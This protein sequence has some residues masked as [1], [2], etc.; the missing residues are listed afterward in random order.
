MSS[1]KSD[2]QEDRDRGRN[3][4]RDDDRNE[5]SDHS[6]AVYGQDEHG[7][8]QV[9]VQQ[10]ITGTDKKDDLTGTSGNDTIFG[11]GGNDKIDGGDGNDTIDAG[12]GNDNIEGGK[13]DD[14]ITGGAGND[15]IDGGKGIDV[16]VY[17][18]NFSDYKLTLSRDGGHQG[19]DDDDHSAMTVHDLRSGAPDGVDV[20]KNVEVLRF[21]DGE[22]KDGQFHPSLRVTAVTLLSD[23]TG[24][25]NSDFVTSQALQTVTGTFGGTLHTGDIIEVSADGNTWVTA[26][27]TGGSTWSATGITLIP[28]SG[29]QIITR[30]IDSHGTILAGASHSYVL[31]TTVA[32][33][34]LS[35]AYDESGISLTDAITNATT[36]TLS[37]DAE[38]GATVKVY[39]GATLIGTVTANA[40]GA[41]SLT[42]SGLA[43]GTHNFSAAQTDLA[44]N[45]SGA[46]TVSSMTVDTVAL[47][48]SL[49]AVFADSG[50][51]S[52]DKITNAIN[53]TLSGTAEKG[54]AVHVYD[55]ALS[56]GTVT[57]N[58]ATGAW[59]LNVT[60]L[61][62][63]AHSFTATQ[64]DVAGNLSGSSAAKT[65]TVD[66]AAAA[67]LVTPIMGDGIINA[68]EQTNVTISGGTT[69][70]EA[71][72]PLT[73][74]VSDGSATVTGTATVVSDGSWSATGLDFSGLNEGLLTVSVSGTDVAGNLA[75]ATTELNKDSVAS[76]TLSMPIATDGI[77]NASEKT[78]VTISGTTEGVEEGIWLT[79]SV[80]GGTSSVTGTAMVGPGGAWTGDFGLTSLTDGPLT[81]SVSGT[82]AAGN[83]VSA[84]TTVVLDA[85]VTMPLLTLASDTGILGTDGITSVGTVNVGGLEA[86]AS[87]QYSTDNGT[88]WVNGTGSSLTL[89]GD[90]TKSVLVQQT[91]AAGNTSA[92]ATLDLTLDTSI[93]TPTITEVYDSVGTIGPVA[94]GDVTDDQQPKLSGQAEAGSTVNVFDGS[95]L[96]GTTLADGNGDWTFTPVTALAEAQHS[97]TVTATDTAGNSS[98]SSAYGIGISLV[99]ENFAPALTGTPAALIGG[100]E[101]LPYTVSSE[102]LLA[103]FTDGNSGDVLSVSGLSADHGTVT[104]NGNGTYT[105]TPTP[106]YNGPVTLSYQVTDGHAGYSQLTTLSF[107]LTPAPDAAVIGAPSVATV[108]E[109]VLVDTYGN[110]NAQGIIPITDADGASQ[111]AFNPVTLSGALGSLALLASGSYTYTVDNSAVQLLGASAAEV[112]TF[113]VSSADGTTQNLSFAV[114][115]ANDA[116]VIGDPTLATVSEDADVNLDGNLVLTDTLSITDAD[117]GEDSFSTAVSAVGTTLGSLILNTNGVYTYSVANVDVQYLGGGETATDTFTVTAADGTT[118]EVS[119]AIAGANDTPTLAASLITADFFDGAAK[120]VFAPVTGALTTTDAD[121]NATHTYGIAGGGTDT[122]LLGYDSSLAGAYGTLYLNSA[123]GNYTYVPNSDAI[124]TMP[125]GSTDMDQFSL[126]VDDHA[127]GTASQ[128]LAINL[129]GANDASVIDGLRGPPDYSIGGTPVS[130]APALTLTDADSGTA[131]ISSATVVISAGFQLG[132]ILDYTPLGS[133]TGSYD[134]NTGVL[135]LTGSGTL[136]DYTAVLQSVKFSTDAVGGRTFSFMVSDNGVDSIIVDTTSK[137]L[138]NL[139]TTGFRLPGETDYDFSGFWVSSAGDVNG[140][141]YADVIIGAPFADPNGLS[142]SGASYVVFGHGG[143]FQDVPLSTVDVAAGNGFRINGEDN[144]LAG[145]SVSDAGDVN[146]DGIGDL[147]IG[148][149]RA[150][151]GNVYSAGAS[152]VV[153]GKATGFTADIALSS[154]QNSDGFKISG[155]GVYDRAGYSVSAAGDVNGDGFGDVIVG[156]IN[157]S[158]T[159]G[160]HFANSGPGAAYV[161]FGKA[162]GSFADIDLANLA[163]ADGFRLDGAADADRT[164]C[165]VSSA[166]D[167]NGDGYADLVIGASGASAN[168]NAQSG[169]IYV[170]FGKPAD[171]TN[172]E[173][174]TLSGSD[175]FRIFGAA[176]YDY[177]GYSVSNAGDVNGDGFGDLI[178]GA[179]Y[180]STNNGGSGAAYVVFGSAPGTAHDVSLSNLGSD[181][182][183]IMGVAEGD[184]AGYS[185]SAAGDV[186]GDGYGDLII[187]APYAKPD[188]Q[189]SGESYVLFGKASGF[190]EIDL[191]NLD[192]NDG[193]RVSAVGNGDASGYSVSAAGDVNGDGFDDLIVGAAYA[194]PPGTDQAGESYVIFGSK[195]IVGLDTFVGSGSGTSSAEVFIGTDG[196]DVMTGGGGADAFSA[197]AGNDT[198]HLGAP[199]SSDSSFVKINGGSGV[200]TLVLDG[201]GMLLDLNTAG[202]GSRVQGIEQIDLTGSGDNELILNIRDVLNISDTT[203]RLYVKGDAG[204]LVTSTGQLWAVDSTSTGLIDSGGH[205]FDSYTLHGDAYS[206]GMA[207][208]LIEQGVT[209]LI[210]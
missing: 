131:N 150:S 23:D 198:I 96:L 47:A 152:Y 106:D 43:N 57:A 110:L 21:A 119:F 172:V 81:V 120:D 144:S 182:F 68:S 67:M 102:H 165:Q 178:I 132:D 8:H 22:Y 207:N 130:V 82:D 209:V 115:G 49:N 13:G 64:T 6:G 25:S 122:S 109:D 24:V 70:V 88:T 1:K 15:N 133:I 63:G 78:D 121:H 28:G 167:I 123:S 41:W 112:D 42:K 135:S 26:N 160:D 89:S 179:P 9:S 65:M 180:A 145:F 183:R 153:F 161:I 177:A 171:F 58:A 45:S 32:A 18:G 60:S 10:P 146:G 205:R 20:L 149:S 27:I 69:D 86:G 98:T 95:T 46:S 84:S 162:D 185:V 100:T 108:T 138:D 204:D 16:A 201:S 104:N 173:L 93:A 125:V 31:D 140:D 48:P 166:G 141:G 99:T 199:G 44:G 92:P 187:G 39:D 17:S 196:D 175:G 176:A 151:P 197:G 127:G 154:L 56:L 62:A 114:Y 14:I 174:S 105:I 194:S 143:A 79:I 80:T 202:I 36:A 195:F 76:I 83:S 206:Q 111:E 107:N 38:K 128:T 124:N 74:S 19:D 53:A 61:S 87:W 33:P 117:T 52:T 2:K 137:A 208:L 193:F 85:T 73:I 126:T 77:I 51:S 190:A 170:V 168:G 35:L 189:P 97:F 147:I 59:S 184:N 90:G 37:G 139:G 157:A 158:A 142:S 103:G 29:T 186:N 91:D 50:V 30:T 113:T 156:A 155:V 116:A 192:P 191:A 129:Y 11:L 148:A 4:D 75:S 203:N 71:G 55:G 181:G 34:S 72:R 188:G 7:H 94:I 101:D 5:H 118:K 12:S 3:D 54:A 169:A 163:L 66:T 134:P 159:G 200:D 40:D 136:A 210:S 164:G